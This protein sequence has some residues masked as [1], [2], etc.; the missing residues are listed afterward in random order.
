MRHMSVVRPPLDQ[1]SRQGAR[2][3]SPGLNPL[4]RAQTRAW[5][6]DWLSRT[7]VGRSIGREEGIEPLGMLSGSWTSLRSRLSE[8]P[9][10]Q[11]VT[12]YSMG[13]RME[14]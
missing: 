13:L 14:C 7:D 5:P 1:R 8:T 4:S 9:H 3:G 12:K 10:A 6:G 2:R 11:Y